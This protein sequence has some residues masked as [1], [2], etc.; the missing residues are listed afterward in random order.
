MVVLGVFLTSSG[1]ALDKQSNAKCVFNVC[2][3][4]SGL[5]IGLFSCFTLFF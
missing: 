3:F 2:F 1:D 4:L 5:F